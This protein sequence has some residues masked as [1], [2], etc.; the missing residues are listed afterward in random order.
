[1]PVVGY[2]TFDVLE[3]VVGATFLVGTIQ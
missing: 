3:P 2:G 1:L